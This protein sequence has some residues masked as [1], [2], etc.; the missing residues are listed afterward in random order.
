MKKF[1]LCNDGRSPCPQSPGGLG[2]DL[3]DKYFSNKN[4]KLTRRSGRRL[5]SPRSGRPLGGTA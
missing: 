3:A 1:L 2:D 4:P 5:P